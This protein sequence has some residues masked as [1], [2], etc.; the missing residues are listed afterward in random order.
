VED[1]L[2]VYN[3]LSEKGLSVLNKEAA[4]L[5]SLID[6]KKTINDIFYLALEK[7]AHVEIADIIK[8]FDDFV[9]SETV[10]FNT[11]KN[12]TKLFSKKPKHLGVWLHITNQCN[13]RC[14]YCYVWKTNNK[15][16][17]AIAQKS[18]KKII[19]GAKEHGFKKITVKFSGGECLLELS[20]V[21]DLVH[22]GR[23]LAKQAKI[24]IDFAVLTN[25]VLLTEEVS[26][27]LKEEN[28]RAAVSLDGLEKYHDAQRIFANGLGSFKFVEKGIENLLKA[29]VPFN[30]SVTITSKNVEN[31]P[32]LTK[33]LL[34]KNIPFVF[35]F[36][37]ENPFVKEKLEGDDKK[38]VEFLKKAYRIIY[39]NPPRYSLI[40]GLL[41]RV[42]FKRPHLYNC[43][44]GNNYIVVRQ[45]GKIVPCQMTLE[46]PIGSIDDKDLI[47]TMKIGNFVKPKN[48]TVEG[49][50]PC[51]TCQWKY[52]CCG[53]CPLLTY[54]QKGRYTVNSP[55]CA[56]YKALIPEV[57]QIEAKRLIKYGF[58]E[59]KADKQEL[60][61]LLPL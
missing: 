15:M 47:E 39:E 20:K 2:L 41:D 29:K 6:G 46:K 54:E 3:P 11:P 33:Y 40:N 16:S 23:K 50:N 5:F 28:I 8:V 13:L 59:T 14:T 18:I 7:D 12:K 38:L 34:G 56:V 45:D 61:S 26:K 32:E 19:E 43:G 31:I 22:L 1:F 36:Y 53:G 49:K 21:L 30:V 35:N 44:M 24:E 57:L 25:G 48:L 55:Y 42:S 9:S 10:Y 27:K 37:R 51:N 52:I 58:E 4:F 17:E 60:P